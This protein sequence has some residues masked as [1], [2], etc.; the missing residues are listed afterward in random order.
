[1]AESPTDL[2]PGQGRLASVA[3]IS[4]LAPWRV[5]AA[6]A[7]RGGRCLSPLPERRPQGRSGEA[8]NWVMA[9]VMRPDR[10][11]HVASAGISASPAPLS[12]TCSGS[13]RTSHTSSWL[14]AY[15]AGAG[16]G[17]GPVGAARRPAHLLTSP[18][19]PQTS[20]SI[21]PLVS[22][23]PAMFSVFTGFAQC[24]RGSSLARGQESRHICADISKGDMLQVSKDM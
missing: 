19:C 20:R 8:G 18:L 21:T 23:R 5:F 6:A 4:A 12:S 10:W 2:G 9:Q 24:T 17:S 16:L 1:M 14:G 22:Q 3:D 15:A 7:G 11:R 13:T